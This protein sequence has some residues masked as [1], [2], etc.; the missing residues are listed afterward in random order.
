MQH[1]VLTVPVI[2]YICFHPWVHDDAQYMSYRAVWTQNGAELKGNSIWNFFFFLWSRPTELKN[3]ENILNITHNL[4]KK[5]NFWFLEI[6]CVSEKVFFTDTCS[7]AG[8]V[9][10]SSAPRSKYTAA[11]KYALTSSSLVTH[12]RSDTQAAHWNLSW[13]LRQWD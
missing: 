9:T 13:P 12:Q 6:P 11:K 4:Q 1:D 2:N 7:R 5:P 3:K 8:P 10:I